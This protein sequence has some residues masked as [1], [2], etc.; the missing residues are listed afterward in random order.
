MNEIYR[1]IELRD[2]SLRAL[3]KTKEKIE[4]KIEEEERERGSKKRR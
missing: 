4:K 2:K 3:V 1:E